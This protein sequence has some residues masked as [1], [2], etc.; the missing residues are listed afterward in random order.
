MKFSE[1]R[2]WYRT[3]PVVFKIFIWL[4]L[5]RPFIDGLYFLKEFNVLLSAPYLVGM[6]T[7]VLG[8]YTIYRYRKIYFSPVDQLFQLY[9]LICTLSV[10]ILLARFGPQLNTL[11]IIFKSLTPLIIFF[12]AR[13]MVRNLRD[14][15]GILQTFLY[16][17]CPVFLI[18]IYEVGFEPIKD[19]T[20]RGVE[21]IEGIYADVLNYSIYLNLSMLVACYFLLKHQGSSGAVRYRNLLILL[22]LVSIMGLSQMNHV[23][24]LI[25]FLSL[26]ILF[27]FFLTRAGI[28]QSLLFVLIIFFIVQFFV[29]DTMEANLQ[30]LIRTDLE[31]YAG[32]R[33]QAQALHGR[34]GR[35]EYMW[36]NF[37]AEPW[38]AQLLGM[39]Y[40][41]ER[42]TGQITAG[43]HND[44]LRILFL[45]GFIGLILYFFFLL[46]LFA[47]LKKLDAIR[48][49]L[50]LGAMSM[51]LLYSI[52]T[53]PTF[54]FHLMNI[55]SVIYAMACLPEH[56]IKQGS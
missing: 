33:E 18:M 45:T 29:S 10:L 40:T 11:K 9:F 36:E 4:I 23:A 28:L 12:I 34:W 7:F 53:L 2:A 52:T 39:P 32:E 55:I 6:G 15:E 38:L 56:V 37:S 43:V 5:L 3:L 16:S 44:F 48:Q 31:V 35:W 13:R 27:V 14:V 8:I 19:V 17:A 24:S 51:V 46:T 30:E 50:L 22:T 49:F 47:Q 1:W 20:T 42:I 41:M 25:V 54:Y 21:R 26:C